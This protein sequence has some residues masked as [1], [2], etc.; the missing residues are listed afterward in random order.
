[1]IKATNETVMFPRSVVTVYQTETYVVLVYVCLFF[2][3]VEKLPSLISQ[4][5]NVAVIFETETFFRAAIK[6]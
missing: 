6:T 2:Q 3:N 5:A 4:R 1:M